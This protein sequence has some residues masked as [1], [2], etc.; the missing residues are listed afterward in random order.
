[1]AF[2]LCAY[3]VLTGLLYPWLR[4][5][6]GTSRLVMI[7]A[8]LGLAMVA[9]RMVGGAAKALLIM[10]GLI[11]GAPLTFAMFVTA[12]F[13]ETA[14]GALV[15]LIVVPAVVLALEKAHLSPNA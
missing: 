15:H 6:L 4:G 13:V 3:G 12:Y 1:M 2:E 14:V 8:T 7:L 10:A 9:G 5:K 11:P